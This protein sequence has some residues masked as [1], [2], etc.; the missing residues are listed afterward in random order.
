[1]SFVYGLIRGFR[2]P[3]TLRLSHYDQVIHAAKEGGGIAIGKRPHLM[4]EIRE[5][6][7]WAMRN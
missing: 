1:M 6:S 4:R 2:P 7:L 3:G 5:G